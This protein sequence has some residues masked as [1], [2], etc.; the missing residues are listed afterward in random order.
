[1]PRVPRRRASVASIGP[2][3]AP[4]DAGTLHAGFLALLPCIERHGRFYFRKVNCHH[5]KEECLAEMAALVGPENLIGRQDRH[6]KG[7]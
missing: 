2:F 3:P 6:Q 7:R 4:S 1:M 5:K